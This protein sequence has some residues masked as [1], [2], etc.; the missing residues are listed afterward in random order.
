[1]TLSEGEVWMLIG[2]LVVMTAGMKAI[3]PALVGGRELPA[4]C[5]GVIALMAP[6]L[7][8]ALVATAVFADG[9]HLSV[10]ADTAGVAV[11]TVLL[12][13]RAPLVLVCAVAM[14]VTAALRALG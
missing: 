14:V 5:A 3:G 6:A 10:G 1:M 11:A 7:L 12:V 13:R 2:A 4:W 9:P 8:A